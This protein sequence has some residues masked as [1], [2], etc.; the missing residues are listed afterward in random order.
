M[1]PFAEFFAENYSTVFGFARMRVNSH[2]DAEAIASE[3]FRIAWENFERTGEL[4]IAWTKRVVWN[5]AGDHYRHRDRETRRHEALKQQRIVEQ[6]AHDK[7]AFDDISEPLTQ[8]MRD[9]PAQYRDV[10]VLSYWH[11]LSTK[12]IA[13]VLGSQ[14]DAVR[15]QL[16]RARHQLA[17]NLGESIKERLQRGA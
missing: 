11:D 1:E 14:H 9:L 6:S 13:Q 15:K 5:L 4:S 2:H 7:H 3:A 10:L 12:E 8:A 16:S 17:E